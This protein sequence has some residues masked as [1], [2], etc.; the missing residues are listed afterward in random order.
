MTT[1]VQDSQLYRLTRRHD[2]LGSPQ[3]LNKWKEASGVNVK[4]RTVRRRLIEMGLPALSPTKKPALT[5]HHKERRVIFANT[6]KRRRTWHNVLFSDEAKIYL[7]ARVKRVRRHVGEKRYIRT[8]KYPGRV[9][10]WGCMSA[11]GFGDIYI[12]EENLTAELYTT[13]LE[14]AM[15]PSA[16]R[17]MKGVWWLQQ[18]GDSKHTARR[19]RDWLAEHNIRTFDWPANSPDLNPIENV[20]NLLKDRVAARGATSVQELKRYIQEEWDAMSM[21]YAESLVGS[22]PK[23]MQDVLAANGDAIKY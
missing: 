19:T 15:L 23:R 10:V 18:D 17:L 20:W 9:N 1:K 12:F 8:T 5:P 22:M 21:T 3:L 7:G 2:T 6:H 11:Q 13:I 16:E 14:E 4:P